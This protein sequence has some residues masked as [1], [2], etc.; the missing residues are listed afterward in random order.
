[1]RPLSGAARAL[2]CS[3]RG[4]A[5]R[6]LLFAG[7]LACAGGAGCDLAYPE[8]VV[9]NQTA[10]HFQLRNL[11]FNGCLWDTVLAHGESTAPA[12][13]LPGDDRVHFERFDAAAYDTRREP[14]SSEHPVPLWFNYQ[15][16][17]QYR[18][19]Y[20]EFRVFHITLDDLEQDFSVPGPYG[21]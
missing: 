5:C 18:V 13:C 6:A 1:M 11:S 3:P 10:P 4:T 19:G 15:T 2:K 20:G 16:R 9:V 12:R 7:L 14:D 8:V 21:H 17:T